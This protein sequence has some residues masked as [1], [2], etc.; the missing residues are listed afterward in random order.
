ML[1]VNLYPVT[2]ISQ[3]VFLIFCESTCEIRHCTFNSDCSFVLQ[4]IPTYFTFSSGTIHLNVASGEKHKVKDSSMRLSQNSSSSSSIKTHKT[5]SPV[6]VTSRRKPAPSTSKAVHTAA[7]VCSTDRCSRTVSADLTHD[8]AKLNIGVGLDKK[9]PKRKVAKSLFKEFTNKSPQPTSAFSSLKDPKISEPLLS[10]PHVQRKPRSVTSS[11]SPEIEQTTGSDELGATVPSR[12]GCKKRFFF[13]STPSLK[14]RCTVSSSESLG[15]K[16]LSLSSPEEV[17]STSGSFQSKRVLSQRLSDSVGDLPSGFHDEIP[18][19][20]GSEYLESCNV[21]ESSRKPVQRLSRSETALDSFSPKASLSAQGADILRKRSSL[22]EEDSQ[23]DSNRTS[24][25]SS[26]FQNTTFDFDSVKTPSITLEHLV[27]PLSLNRKQKSLG[28][29]DAS[30]CKEKRM[31]EPLFNRRR[32]SDRIGPEGKE[33]VSCNNRFSDTV[34]TRSSYRSASPKFHGM[35]SLSAQGAGI[36]RKR[37]SIKEQD[38]QSGSNRTSLTSSRFQNTTFDF[39]SIETP[40]ITLEHLVSPLSSNRKRKSLRWQDASVCKE[41]RRSEPL[42][43]RRR[44]IDG[45]GPEGKEQVSCNNRFSDTVKTRSSYRSASPKFHGIHKLIKKVSRISKTPANDLP[46]VNDERQLMKTPSSVKSV[47]DTSAVSG[48]IKLITTPRTQTLK[49][50]SVDR[51]KL[52]KDQKNPKCRKENLSD[53]SG[54]MQLR[55]TLSDLRSPRNDLR[56]ISGV[57]QPMKTPKCSKSPKNDLRDVHG[58]RKLTMTPKSPKSPK[59]DLRDVRGVRKLTTTPKSPKSPKNDL[60]DVRG[61]R[62]RTTPKSPKSPKN[63]LTDVRGVKK[64]MT[65]PKSP[66]S[67]KNDLRDVR[68]V[69]KL[70]TTPK[71]PKSPKNDLTDVRGVR[72][73]MTT[74]KSPKSPKNDLRDVRG[75]KKLMTTPRSPKSPKNDKRDVRGVRKLMTT[76][77]QKSRKNDLRD[78]RGVKQLMMTSKSPKSPK[79]DL[80]DVCGVKRFMASPKGIKSVVLTDLTDSHGVRRLMTTPQVKKSPKSDLADVGEK[81][82]MKTSSPS[83]S[84]KGLTDTNDVHVHEKISLPPQGSE[85]GGRTL[86]AESTQ[87]SPLR[88]IPQVLVPSVVTGTRRT[89]HGTKFFNKVPKE[90]V[91]TEM[92]FDQKTVSMPKDVKVNTYILPSVMNLHVGH[93]AIF[94]LKIL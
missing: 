80:R 15:V 28:W 46:D 93:V 63:D 1:K 30:V 12:R 75:V 56:N 62:K 83:S 87:K 86:R 81:D 19:L 34:R 74:P 36:L 23:S 44:I 78:V 50:D 41:K 29:Q 61:V 40:S 51:T 85:F 39:N 4:E 27:S 89:R 68:G 2:L 26:R 47:N 10:T 59:N 22:K 64:L 7:A 5:V 70:M 31:S 18:N 55:K 76:R 3:P 43:K 32:I 6:K 92:C 90:D 42:F 14:S 8:I 9:R 66:K 17:V 54:V 79:N 69:K 58:V 33:Q 88:S 77:S 73:L 24:L 91:S 25:T 72:K 35:A 38:S 20:S 45:I 48:R 49:T 84:S 53:L 67:P 37:S 57:K 16:R 60:R 11:S 13:S 82:L 52:M 94:T 21:P 65:T 71:I